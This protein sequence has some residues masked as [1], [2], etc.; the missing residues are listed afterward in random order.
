MDNYKFRI[1]HL[2][3]YYDPLIEHSYSKYRPDI[4]KRFLNEVFNFVNIPSF[5]P[6]LEKEELYLPKNKRK[7][8]GESY[9]KKVKRHKKNLAKVNSILNEFKNCSDLLKE[10]NEWTFEDVSQYAMDDISTT[11]STEKSKSDTTIDSG[12]DVSSD[13]VN[14]EINYSTS[15]SIREETNSSCTETSSIDSLLMPCKVFSMPSITDIFNTP[16][17]EA[18][19]A[20]IEDVST[21]KGHLEARKN[22]SLLTLL[23][24]NQTK[25]KKTVGSRR[26]NIVKHDY[27]VNLDSISKELLAKGPIQHRLSWK[28]HLVT[29]NDA[30][31]SGQK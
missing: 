20:I 21:V 30:N 19:D 13:L 14:S 7:I 16:N 5:L 23:K 3:G 2:S 9:S 25:Y 10:S 28:K 4:V 15:S 6:S 8:D 24:A 17:I 11:N 1:N 29:C 12:L 18:K 31:V 27:R 22:E 26:Y